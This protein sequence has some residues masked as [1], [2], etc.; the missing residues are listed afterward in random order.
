MSRYGVRRRLRKEKVGS[1]RSVVNFI[2]MA[3]K[4]STWQEWRQKISVLSFAGVYSEKN[5]ATRKK[6]SRRQREM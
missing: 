5:A 6:T 3:D 4:E 2:T 1:L